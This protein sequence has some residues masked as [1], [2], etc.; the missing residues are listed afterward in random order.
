MRAIALVLLLLGAMTSA[1][2]GADV[3]ALEQHVQRNPCDY[4]ARRDL[5]VLHV[6]SGNIPAAYHHAA[7]LTW[8]GPREYVES[9]EGAVF[10]RSRGN[11]DRAR[12][13][14]GKSLATITTAVDAEHMLLDTCLNGAI[15][16]QATRLRRDIAEM[17]ERAVATAAEARGNDPVVRMALAQLAMTLD[18][19]LVF[20]GGPSAKR[21]RLRALRAAA[22]RAEAAAA[23]VPKAP[24][25]RRLLAVIRSRLAELDGVPDLW[26]L[27]I[28][29]AEAARALD[30]EDAHLAE[31]LWTLHLR[32][33][34]WEEARIWQERVKAAVGAS[35]G[36]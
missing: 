35:Q 2:C 7:W 8:L 28:A 21:S 16:Q 3:A 5:V 29:E 10:I 23:I 15:A 34:H 20:E 17:A 19:A 9:P 33:G 30:P 6:E 13:D 36:K 12:R 25:P 14:G 18:D 24:G 27:A 1:A 4:V 22:S 26:D 31:L 11:R 32:A